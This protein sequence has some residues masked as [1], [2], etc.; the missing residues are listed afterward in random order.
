MAR[1]F[2]IS[3]ILAVA[4]CAVIAPVSFAQVPLNP[5]Y[6]P[7][8][9]ATISGKNPTDKAASERNIE[10]ARSA[11]TSRIVGAILGI[12]GVVAIFAILN[13][14]WFLV[15]SGGRE[16]VITQHKKGLMWAIIGLLLIILSY[17]I[18]RFIISIPFQANETPAPQKQQ[19]PAK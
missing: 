15:A 4:V 6:F 14:S 5:N 13:N 9:A 2:F 17:S 1:R 11:L 12:A 19:Q 7:Q 8:G 18:I 10:V 3:I 16:E